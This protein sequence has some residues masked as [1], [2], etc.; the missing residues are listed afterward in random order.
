MAYDKKPYSKKWNGKGRLTLN[1]ESLTVNQGHPSPFI[2]SMTRTCPRVLPEKVK[3]AL[4]RLEVE[5]FLPMRYDLV[6]N[7]D[8]KPKR[9]LVP[10]VPNLIFV[11]STQA[12]ITELKMTRRELLPLRYMTDRVAK[13]TS[14]PCCHL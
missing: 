2:L 14:R 5:N 7:K 1:P 11:H 12:V 10:A 3:E 9:K 8:G 13:N 4:D 6:K